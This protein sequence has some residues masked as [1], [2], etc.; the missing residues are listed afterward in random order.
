[1]CCISRSIRISKPIHAEYRYS[2]W[3]DFFSAFKRM[4][5]VSVRKQIANRFATFFCISIKSNS[6]FQFDAQNT[7]VMQIPFPIQT[8]FMCV[9]L[10]WIHSIWKWQQPICWRS[11]PLNNLEKEDRESERE[12]VDK[13]SAALLFCFD[14]SVNQS[15]QNHWRFDRSL[16][17]KNGFSFGCLA[18]PFYGFHFQLFLE[19]VNNIHMWI[20]LHRRDWS[21]VDIFFPISFFCA[22]LILVLNLHNWIR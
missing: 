16:F 7:R 14:I 4:Q 3:M 22:L 17:I 18:M 15:N 12:S 8:L 11:Y 9:C 5:Q 6:S 10:H 21:N 2:N 1:M 13:Q 19:F 20:R